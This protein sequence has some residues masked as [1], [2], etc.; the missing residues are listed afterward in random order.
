MS[1][2]GNAH[3]RAAALEALPPKAGASP[4]RRFRV[5]SSGLGV[6]GRSF[7]RF[8]V[9]SLGVEGARSAGSGPAWGPS[10]LFGVA[11]PGA[12]AV[13]ERQRGGQTSESVEAG[14]HWTALFLRLFRCDSGI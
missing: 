11:V 4:G 1:C 7:R 6:F 9:R 2:T 13:A 14:T 5:G 3:S 10:A 12:N 8:L